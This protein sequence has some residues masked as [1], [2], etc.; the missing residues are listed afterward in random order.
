M[1]FL[2]SIFKRA[3]DRVANAAAD[4]VVDKVVDSIRGTASGSSSDTYSS[5]QNNFSQNG[6]SFSQSNSSAVASG[7]E[8]GFCDQA[9]CRRRLLQCL[10]QNFS[11]YSVQENVPS[12]MFGERGGLPYSIVVSQGS[13]PK[14]VIMII[15][16]TTCYLRKYRFSREAAE[17]KGVTVINFIG[18]YPN[19]P[20]YILN[21][22][23]SYL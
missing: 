2:D 21:R 14:L 7:Y 22:L 9:E 6:N 1:G 8:D 13:T 5:A 20:D 12:M 23:R 16:K 18:H 19:R 10:A 3:T 17:S 15:G 4:R 11:S